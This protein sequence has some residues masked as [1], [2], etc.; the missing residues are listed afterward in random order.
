[1]AWSASLSRR[2]NFERVTGAGLTTQNFTNSPDCAGIS[3]R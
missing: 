2:L 1:M 3:L